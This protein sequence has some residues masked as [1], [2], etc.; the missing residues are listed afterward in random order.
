MHFPVR[1]R[2][3]L[4]ANASEML[5]LSSPEQKKLLN[6]LLKKTYC[7]IDCYFKW[8]SANLFVNF[9]VK[10]NKNAKYE[11]IFFSDGQHFSH[12]LSVIFKG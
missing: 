4:V 7:L 1:T 9:I 8:I 3:F 12:A 6:K 10:T 5:A 2:L 11:V